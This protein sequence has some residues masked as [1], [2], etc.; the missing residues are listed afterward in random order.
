VGSQ[1]ELAE[2]RLGAPPVLAGH[3]T[4]EQRMPGLVAAENNVLGRGQAGEHA[5]LLEGARQ[6]EALK[7][8]GVGTPYEA[9]A[10]GQADRVGGL[11]AGYHVEGRGLPRTVGPDKGGHR[12]L[13]YLEAAA[14]QGADSAE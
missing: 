13:G 3:A 8:A 9:P 5:G 14:I 12:S 6:A 4:A 1:A 7:P 2:K 10:E 11:V